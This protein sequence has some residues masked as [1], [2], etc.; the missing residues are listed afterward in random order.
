MA[1]TLLAIFATGSDISHFLSG[2]LITEEAIESINRATS[3]EITKISSL[4]SDCA[5]QPTPKPPCPSPELVEYSDEET[6]N[7]DQDL[8]NSGNQ[9]VDSTV[10]PQFNREHRDGEFIN[11][12][13]TGWTEHGHSE[14]IFGN[15]EQLRQP[16]NYHKVVTEKKN[17]GSKRNVQFRV[18]TGHEDE[19]FD[20]TCIEECGEENG[21]A[22]DLPERKLSITSCAP[23]ASVMMKGVGVKRR[24]ASAYAVMGSAVRPKMIEFID[25]KNLTANGLLMSERTIETFLYMDYLQQESKKT[26]RKYS[27]YQSGQRFSNDKL[28]YNRGTEKQLPNQSSRKKRI[29]VPPEMQVSFIFDEYFSAIYYQF[30]CI[31]CYLLLQTLSILK[32]NWEA[33]IRQLLL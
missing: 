25:E 27:D 13:K 12:V 19:S 15:D 2:N 32:D 9:V 8:D 26:D 29:D 7:P 20:P 6:S 4:F 1:N 21:I 14:K 28:S 11:H 10:C 23:D 31:N 18:P 17:S 3:E 33:F 24:P 22:E 5:I 30:R 16:I